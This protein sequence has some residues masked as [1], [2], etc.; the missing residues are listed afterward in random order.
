MI[1]GISLRLH[2][3]KIADRI[4]LKKM[5]RAKR[6]EWKRLGVGVCVYLSLGIDCISIWI[7]WV[8]G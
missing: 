7:W 6:I 3:K 5:L 8:H 4:K 1:S 2:Q